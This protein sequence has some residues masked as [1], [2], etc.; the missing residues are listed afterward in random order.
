MNK[1]FRKLVNIVSAI[2]ITLAAIWSIYKLLELIKKYD[3]IS[4]LLGFSKL[5]T[6][7][8]DIVDI[9]DKGV[10]FLAYNSADAAEAFN[11]YLEFEG[12]KKIGRFGKSDLYEYNGEEIIIKRSKLFN[13]FYLFEI[14]NDEYVG[15]TVDLYQV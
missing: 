15:R 14:F 5:A 7:G 4:I 13:K 2:L 10:K 9:S 8:Q 1:N 6:G 11:D 12:Y 3:L